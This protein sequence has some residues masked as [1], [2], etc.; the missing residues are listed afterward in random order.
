MHS[1]LASSD[2]Y[3]LYQTA[4]RA[5]AAMRRRGDAPA[6]EY[7]AGNPIMSLALLPYVIATNGITML[8][9]ALTG[10]PCTAC[11]L[12]IHSLY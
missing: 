3:H 9:P 11:Q 7:W 12:K 4:G 10:W 1:V 8:T 6:V 2:Q 5:L